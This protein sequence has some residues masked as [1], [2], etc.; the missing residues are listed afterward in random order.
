VRELRNAVERLLILS[1][2]KVILAGDVS[3]LLGDTAVDEILAAPEGPVGSWDNFRD[4]TE[5]AYLTAKLRE[6]DWNIAETSRDL[7]MPRSNLYK[8]MEKLGIPRE[9]Q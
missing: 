5:R 9:P 2:G 4:D 1:P 3:R 6:N 7:K 8:K